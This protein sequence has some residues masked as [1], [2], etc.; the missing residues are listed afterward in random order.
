MEGIKEPEVSDWIKSALG[1]LAPPFNYELITGGRSNLTYTVRDAAGATIVLRRPPISHILPTAHDMEREY[2][3]ISALHPVNYPVATP[4]ALCVDPTINDQPFYLMSF[5]A[6]SILNDP[7]IVDAK[8]PTINQRRQIGESLVETLVELHSYDVGAIGLSD[9]AR[10]D[11]YIERQLKRWYGQFQ[12][13]ATEIGHSVALVEE[14]YNKLRKQIP[15][16]KRVAV[17][18]GDYRLDNTVVADDGSIS[19]V[20]DWE[21]S[22]LG[23]PLADIGTLLVYWTE[24]QDANPPL[25]SV[26]QMP[27]FLTRKEIASAYSEL[28]GVDLELISY[29]VSFGY[30]K[31]ACILEGVYSRYDQGAHGGDRSEVGNYLEQVRLLAEASERALQG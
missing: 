23:D 17:V 4:L 14:M 28:A 7:E 20:L 26:T 2:R 24:P 18:H 5:V 19:A 3:V 29:Y 22:T 1:W 11:G 21:I 30:W 25:A 27:G 9:F 15:V 6:G 10:P 31:L 13:S 16:Q 8:F 12:A